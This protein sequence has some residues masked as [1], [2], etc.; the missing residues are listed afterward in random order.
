MK[1]TSLLSGS[2]NYIHVMSG[3]DNA[4]V[5]DPSSARPVLDFI[6]QSHLTLTH[7]LI[8][9]HHSDHTAGCAELKAQTGCKVIGPVTR[10]TQLAEEELPADATVIRTPGH[11][12]THLCY[13]FPAEKALFSGDTLFLGGCG[14]LFEGTASQMWNSLVKLR[15]L[16][17]GTNVYPGHD[18]TLDNLEFC[19]SI[20]PNDPNVTS[21]LEGI[22]ASGSPDH[23]TLDMEIA[24]NV[25]LMCDTPIFQEATGLSGN[26]EDIFGDL[27]QRKDSW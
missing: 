2:D 23:A 9:H 5:V 18:Y 27:R 11:T 10:S 17:G 15:G 26:P 7:I 24:T 13:H 14:R 1:I 12:A 6:K 16:P 25:F 20:L 22:R 4:I 3:A 21:R 8:T 19:K